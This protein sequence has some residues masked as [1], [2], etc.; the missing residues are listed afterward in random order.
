M[1]LLL[2]LVAPTYLKD[3]WRGNVDMNVKSL[4]KDPAT[5]MSLHFF[6]SSE[7]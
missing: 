1:F 6:L 2:N 4:S 3:S 5:E 7:Y